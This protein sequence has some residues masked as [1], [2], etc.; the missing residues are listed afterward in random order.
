IFGPDFG[1]GAINELARILAAFRKELPEPN[2]TF[3]AGVIA[4]GASASIDES[5]NARAAGKTNIIAATAVATGDFRTLS[6]EQTA[7]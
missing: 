4:G 5:G 6:V 1:D 3:N 2:L 7:R